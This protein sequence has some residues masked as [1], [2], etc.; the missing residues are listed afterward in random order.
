M[1]EGLAAGDAFVGL[2]ETSPG[3]FILMVSSIYYCSREYW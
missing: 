3:K 2:L 1:I